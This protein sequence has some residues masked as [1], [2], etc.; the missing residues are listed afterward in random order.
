M[1]RENTMK[2]QKKLHVI[3][4]A[5]LLVTALFLAASARAQQTW[6]SDRQVAITFDDLPVTPTDGTCDPWLVWTTTDR[7]LSALAERDVTAVGMVNAARTCGQ[8]PGRLRD[9]LL[10]R[11][12][13]VGHDLGNHTASHPDINRVPLESY[14][15]DLEE[16]G[17]P[18]DSLLQERG[19]HLVWFRHPFLHAGDTTA[20]KAGLTERLVVRGWRVAPVTVDNQEWVYAYV[21]HA[22]RERGDSLLAGRVV[23][24]YLD[25]M[26]GAFA[27]FERRS[28]EVLGREIP[29]VLLLHA[30]RLNAD[31]L[32]ALLDRIENRGYRFVPLEDALADPAYARADPYVGPKGP[33]WIERW[34]VAEGGV[35]REG[36]R[37]D[38]WIAETFAR[39]Q[40]DGG[41]AAPGGGSGSGD[42]P[43][44]RQ[45]FER[46]NG[47]FSEALM[48]GDAATMAALYTED[49]VLLTPGGQ[50][51]RGREAIER[52]WTLRPEVRQ[53]FHQ[54]ITETVVPAG[55]ASAVEIGTWRSVLEVDGEI[56][57]PA[58][59]RY[60]LTWARQADGSWR[61]LADTWQ[62]PGAKP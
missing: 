8:D 58:S 43:V 51:V 40:R 25:H 61:I 60:L 6:E 42:E 59:G 5:G 56:G 52:F 20:K 13:E 54:L 15:A 11:W 23:Q 9:P 32:P 53:V 21:Y 45:A 14:L 37:E 48:R 2:L 17:V 31:V 28:R 12:L 57:S 30:N 10:D 27:Y 1:R 44:L 19:R 38:P 55:E 41:A 62:R 26:D 18:V 22:A 3:G 49:G 33:S 36:P 29:Q 39:L 7:L 16:G 47:A 35:V 50:T 34:A 24:A 46:A 4:S